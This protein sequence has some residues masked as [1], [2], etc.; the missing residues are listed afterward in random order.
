MMNALFRISALGLGLGFSLGLGSMMLPAQADEFPPGPM[1]DTVAKTCVQCHAAG[2]VTSQ[3]KSR[4]AWSD[5]VTQMVA[6][7]AAV[8]DA[9]FDKIVD[10]LAKNFPAG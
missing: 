4:A 5:T 1:H 2:Q 8:N 6:N 9:D 3:R 10:Y 7:G